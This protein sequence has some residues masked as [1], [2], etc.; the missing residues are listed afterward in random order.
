MAESFF[1]NDVLVL[2]AIG[3]NVSEAIRYAMDESS[4]ILT[5]FSIGFAIVGTEPKRAEAKIAET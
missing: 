1:V 5:S 3:V 4:K 2:F